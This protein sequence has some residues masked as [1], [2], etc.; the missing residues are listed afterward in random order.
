MLKVPAKRMNPPNRE[1]DAI[2]QV[3]HCLKAVEKYSQ[4]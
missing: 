2:P 4:F 1:V 3:I